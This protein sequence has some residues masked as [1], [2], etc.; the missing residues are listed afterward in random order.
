MG[1]L[2]SRTFKRS[3]TV[4]TIASHCAW[5][6]L[7]PVGQFGKSDG[8]RADIEDVISELVDFGGDPAYGH[9]PTRANDSMVRVIV[10]KRG[11]ATNHQHAHWVPSPG[12][13]Q[14][15]P[16]QIQ[17]QP[18]GADGI[19]NQ[20]PRSSLLEFCGPGGSR[21]GHPRIQVGV[22]GDE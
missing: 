18:P 13:P 16:V 19:A 10:G 17:P 3:V 8:S 15:G 9:L 12:R 22:A 5:W 21:A 4:D 14:E 6:R 11:A 20:R 1:A 7:G 2:G